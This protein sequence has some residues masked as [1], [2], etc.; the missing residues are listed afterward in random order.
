MSKF[1]IRTHA[2]EIADLELRLRIM[3]T[4][5]L[6][7]TTYDVRNDDL[8]YLTPLS[9]ARF[10]NFDIEKFDQIIFGA[11]FQIPDHFK[12]YILLCVIQQNLHFKFAG[13][14]ATRKFLDEVK[15]AIGGSQN[16]KHDLLSNVNQVDIHFIGYWFRFVSEYYGE[17]L[18]AISDQLREIL[19]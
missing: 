1:C 14:R 16:R 5:K 13:G 17:S 12:A 3:A 8:F 10:P 15:S 18:E 9:E 4:P 19:F 11:W 2:R 7:L 6:D